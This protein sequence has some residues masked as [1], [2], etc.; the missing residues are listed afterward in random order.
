MNSQ[1]D[2]APV[3]G[4]S[5]FHAERPFTEDVRE[6]VGAIV[7]RWK[8][9]LLVA[10]LAVLTALAYIWIATPYYS[11]H[12]DI[13]IDPR[14][15]QT[16]D[17][18][19][20]PTGLGTSAAGADTLLLES[21]IEL[22]QSQKVIDKLIADEGLADDSEFGK[23]DTPWFIELAKQTLQS[24][25]Y[26]PNAAL[27]K[28]ESA[29]DRALRKLLRQMRVDR[30]RNTYVI[31]ISISSKDPQ[32]AARIANR[33][34]SIYMAE[35]NGAAAETIRD[36]A[37]LLSD[38]LAE[39]Q[40]S[41]L[42]SSAAVET[43]K[44][45]NNLIDAKQTLL[46]EQR[47]SDLNQ[48]LAQS[49]S[50]MQAAAARRNQVRKA[51][52]DRGQAG[53]QKAEI[54]ESQ[55]LAQL[56][57]Q[58]AAIDSQLAGQRSTLLE[59]HP[60]VRQLKQRQASLAS[61]IRAEYTRILDRLDVTFETARERVSNLGSE[62]DQLKGQLATSN[63]DVVKLR[64]LESQAKI[65][66]S[67]YEA[68]LQRSREA[69]A[70]VDLPSTTA[71]IISTA[72]VSSRPS[73]PPA[74]LLLIA[75]GALGLVIGIIVALLRGLF[76]VTPQDSEDN[77]PA[78]SETP[79]TEVKEEPQAAKSTDASKVEISDKAS[80]RASRT[81]KLVQAVVRGGTGHVGNQQHPSETLGLPFKVL[82][83]QDKQRTRGSIVARAKP[84]LSGPSS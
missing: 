21:Q 13:L 71:R 51:L 65:N 33:L 10:L 23:P 7:S 72:R 84:Y 78:S 73:E 9:V 17:G 74:L 35:V 41:S 29:S 75:A 6:A 82:P 8:T 5:A 40:K 19:I 2:A 16:V 64:E 43:Y 83:A 67:L 12:V 14:E 63:L 53:L 60:V 58:L 3:A 61:A 59:S 80:V 42:D 22:L 45:N 37:T 18:E 52:A 24:V 57:V 30:Q 20:A 25:I 49:R 15:R 11:S 70:Q 55:V 26:G 28:N 47:L 1:K 32:K 34:A 56:Q 77:E 36:A 38:K 81:R 46:I 68:F 76:A 62:V 66:L 39:L 44:K 69:W 4:Y 50:D 31:R 54:G 79:P 48:Q 27:W